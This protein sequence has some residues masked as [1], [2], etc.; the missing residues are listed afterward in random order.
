[1]DI[2]TCT[3]RDFINTIFTSLRDIELCNL[4]TSAFH[5]NLFSIPNS[6]S[7]KPHGEF[8]LRPIALLIG[9]I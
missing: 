8:N 6:L 4:R 7:R 2:E 9:Q 5:N 1:M 3:P